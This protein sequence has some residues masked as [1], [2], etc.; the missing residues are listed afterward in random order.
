MPTLPAAR[1]QVYES[2][3]AYAVD[4]TWDGGICT[5]SPI[6]GGT[7]DVDYDDWVL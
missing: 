4:L 2:P 1:K 3:A 5:T 6:P 7:E